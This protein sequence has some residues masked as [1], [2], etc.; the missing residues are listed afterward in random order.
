MVSIW[1]EILDHHRYLSLLIFIFIDAYICIPKG[2]RFSHK[3]YAVH[4]VL[5][6]N[7]IGGGHYF[8]REFSI[9]HGT[10]SQHCGTLN[11]YWTR[12]NTGAAPRPG[13][14]NGI[15]DL[16]RTGTSRKFNGLLSIIKPAFQ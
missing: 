8:T 4:E 11:G 13:T 16:C 12:I 2:L 14:I 6:I 10:C 9:L 15:I 5:F 3:G 7:K 1:C